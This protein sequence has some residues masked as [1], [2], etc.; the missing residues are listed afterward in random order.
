VR[1]RRECRAGLNTAKAVVG[2]K[3]KFNG[4][5]GELGIVGFMF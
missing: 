1:G 4:F 5:G 3:L 2:F